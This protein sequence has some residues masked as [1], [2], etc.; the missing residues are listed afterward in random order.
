MLTKTRLSGSERTLSRM[1]QIGRY[2]KIVHDPGDNVLD[3]L[4]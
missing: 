1:D 3:A 2:E 4:T